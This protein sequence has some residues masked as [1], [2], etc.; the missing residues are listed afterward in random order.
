MIRTVAMLLAQVPDVSPDP[1]GLP[2]GATIQKLVGGL[3]WYAILACLAGVIVG[4]AMWGLSG[5]SNNAYGVTNGKRAVVISLL[6]AMV[7]AASSTLVGFF[8]DAGNG[9]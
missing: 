2:G 5:L 7:V 4:A 6:G 9:I 8:V 3:A 1:G